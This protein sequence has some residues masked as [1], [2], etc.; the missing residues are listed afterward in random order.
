[1]PPAKKPRHRHSPEQ[2]AALNALYEE[3]EHPTLA[4]RTDLALS[5]GLSVQSLSVFDFCQPFLSLSSI[6]RPNL[7]IVSFRTEGPQLAQRNNGLEASP[8]YPLQTLLHPHT[9]TSTTSNPTAPTL[10][11]KA[12]LNH[13]SNPTSQVLWIFF[14][15]PKAC[16]KG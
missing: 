11:L 8:I 1:M 16:P 10:P 15:N 14:Q 3:T 13:P 12:P 6:G 5:I 2:L 4:Q 7:S 9:Q